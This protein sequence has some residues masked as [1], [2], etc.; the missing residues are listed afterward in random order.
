MNELTQ[1]RTDETG[2]KTR[3]G[4]QKRPVERR[5]GKSTRRRTDDVLRHTEDVMNSMEQGVIVWSPD[6]SCE[7]FNSRVIDV[8]ERP[9]GSLHVGMSLS[10]F[11]GVAVDREEYDQAR[12]EWILDRFTSAKPFTFD[13][14]TPSGRTVQTMARPRDTGGFVVTM[15][16]VTHVHRAAAEIQAAKE[17]AEAAEHSLQEELT[18]IQ[19]EK[20]SIEQDKEKLKR[21]SIV[22]EHAKDVITITDRTGTIEWV[23][24]S[25]VELTGFT[26]EE[27]V[28]HS[29]D[30]LLFGSDTDPSTVL[31]INAAIQ[32]RQGTKTEILNYSKRGRAYWVEMEI[33]PVFNERGEHTNFITVE[34]DITDRKI[35]ELRAARALE[36]ERQH[37]RESE[38]LSQLNE[39]LQSCKSLEELFG[40][41]SAFLHRILPG[42]SGTLYTY[43]NSR[44]VL[45][46]ACAWN[47]G[48]LLDHIRPD[49]CWGLRRGRPYLYGANEVEF[50][51]QHVEEHTGDEPVG[52]YFCM[53]IVAHGETVGL[54]HISFAA[55]ESNQPSELAE[56]EVK[57]A[58]QCAEQ[59]SL[60]I[61]NVRLRD[62]LRDQ[63]IR[64]PLTS[65]FNR[66]YFLESCRREIRRAQGRERMLSIIS[67]D[68]D[69][70]KQFNDNHGHDAGDIVLR[71][72]G[73]LMTKVFVGEDV[74]CRMGGEEFVALLPNRNREEAALLAETLR[75]AVE[76]LV[77]RYGR[78][79]LPRIS[80]SAG[81]ATYP[82][83][84]ETPQELLK[85]ADKAL[86]QAKG[87][88]R[89]CVAAAIPDNDTAGRETVFAAE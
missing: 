38:L 86:Y 19:I 60:A 75:V 87:Q 88:G 50:V 21:T 7:M 54:L 24:R 17:R 26:L 18:A 44:D 32:D 47:D 12:A 40:V 52:R 45:E 85:V 35:S 71:S 9:A 4:K 76:E 81:I 56:R 11:L 72:L 31:A 36:I 59:I 69:H 3:S 30:E 61:A 41:V 15:T 62:Q 43:S 25:F 78:K 55:A 49:D 73:D 33:V 64:D 70:F 63:S 80:I 22:A 58:K 82:S 27:A 42:S 16:D 13:R 79:N 68:V 20:Q 34:R 39:W 67:V 28:G 51:C 2:S 1:T 57:L 84:G 48:V 10:D 65:L 14:Q 77:V 8:L 6:G 5:R 53:P 74:A 23:N 37:Q 66:R 83:D 46:G 89:N 29:P